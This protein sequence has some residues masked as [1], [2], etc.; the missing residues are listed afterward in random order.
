MS[1][2]FPLNKLLIELLRGGDEKKNLVFPSESVIAMMKLNSGHE[3]ET[4]KKNFK[5]PSS[6]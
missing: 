1:M 2:K 5:F 3:M 4:G 6:A